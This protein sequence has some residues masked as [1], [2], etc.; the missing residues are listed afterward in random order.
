[1]TY[2]LSDRDRYD[3]IVLGRS[4]SNRVKKFL[5]CSVLSK[6]CERAK[7]PVLTVK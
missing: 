1:M 2:Q 7:C 3:L 5:L 6:V 4:E